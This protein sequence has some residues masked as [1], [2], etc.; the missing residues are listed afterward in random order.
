MAIAEGLFFFFISSFVLQSVVVLRFTSSA[1]T[2]FAVG[3]DS[4][5]AHNRQKLYSIFAPARVWSND[6]RNVA[7][8]LLSPYY[9]EWVRVFSRGSWRKVRNRREEILQRWEVTIISDPSAVLGRAA[10]TRAAGRPRGKAQ[11]EAVHEDFVSSAD[12]CAG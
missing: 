10:L 3:L 5:C 4:N 6:I 7:I 11:V 1:F 2:F 9:R 12:E 8:T